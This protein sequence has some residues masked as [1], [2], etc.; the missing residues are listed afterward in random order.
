MKVEEG[1]YLKDAQNFMA[2]AQIRRETLS[3]R[4]CTR[5]G[6]VIDYDQWLVIG[7]YMKEGTHRLKN[8]RSNQIRKVIDV[9]IISIN[10][11]PV[12]L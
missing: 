4:A 11:H 7:Q 6:R 9:L 2:D 3:I 10:N 1:I 5:D 12:Y 8:P